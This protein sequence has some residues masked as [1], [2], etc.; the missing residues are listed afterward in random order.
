MG[1]IKY[2]IIIPV[3]NGAQ[4]LLVLAKRLHQILASLQVPIE[5]IF[6]D[7]G[8]I[9]SSWEI[10]KQIKA[11][12]SLPVTIIQLEKNY[13]QHKATL[14][15]IC[16][17]SGE[18]IITMDDD[19]QHPPEEIPQLITEL[20]RQGADLV[21]GI[22]ETHLPLNR[23]IPSNFFKWFSKNV[24][25]QHGQWSAFRFIKRSLATTIVT[26][27][28]APLNIDQVAWKYAKK[29]I[30]IQVNLAK[31]KQGKSGYTALKLLK[32]WVV[33]L[34]LLMGVTYKTERHFTIKQKIT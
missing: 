23:K 29:A 22:S 26:S 3:Y 34:M 31:R 18:V 9:D 14:C 30:F 8:S 33:S 20:E 24:F 10:L 19:L 25:G 16:E 32:H 2:S 13:G 11:Q 21:Y 15:G 28:I 27:A 4:T 7:D 1:S 5:I 12:L 17:S 6:I